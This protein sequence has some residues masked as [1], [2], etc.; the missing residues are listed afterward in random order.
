MK[1]SQLA[2]SPLVLSGGDSIL[3]YWIMSIFV[4]NL[5]RNSQNFWSLIWILWK[6]PEYCG[7]QFKDLLGATSY[8]LHQTNVKRASWNWTNWHMCML[9][10]KPPF[11][12]IT[13][14]NWICGWK[15][16]KKEISSIF[17]QHSE[18]LIHRTR[19]H[20][21]FHG[22]GP[23]HLFAMKIRANQRL[24][25]LD[26]QRGKAS[27]WDGIPPE[28]CLTFWDLFCFIWFN[29]Q[30]DVADSPGMSIQLLFPYC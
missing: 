21:Y 2:N 7:T 5:E 19:Q 25:I 14:N 3:R 20:Y 22:S 15:Q 6:T 16:S 27:G 13:L 4:S 8:Y 9:T 24:L 23:S 26:M 28:V 18:F 17:R 1:V 29:I 11:S 12:L 10:W 30:S